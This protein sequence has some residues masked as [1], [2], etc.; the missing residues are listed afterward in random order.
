MPNQLTI[1]EDAFP[2]GLRIFQTLHPC[3]P[4]MTPLHSIKCLPLYSTSKLL[5]KAGDFEDEVT[6]RSGV[7]LQISLVRCMN[8]NS[9]TG[10]GTWVVCIHVDLDNVYE[11]HLEFIRQLFVMSSRKGGDSDVL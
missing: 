1:M 2:G 8:L 7:Q 11:I 5:E 4:S 3:T 9:T 10:I 6:T